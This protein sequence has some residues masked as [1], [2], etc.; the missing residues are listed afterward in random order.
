MKKLILLAAWAIAG[1]LLAADK[2][3]KPVTAEFATA[4]EMKDNWEA[5]TA[6]LKEK[7]E[8]LPEDKKP[9][10]ERDWQAFI[11]EKYQGTEE[12][13]LFDGSR[14]D[15]VTK[16]YAIEL[17]WASET[18]KWAESIGQ[19]LWYATNLDKKPG[20]ILLVPVP[21]TAAASDSPET[22]ELKRGVKSN[23]HKAITVC[24]RAGIKL[25][26]E[27]LYEYTGKTK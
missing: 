9:R 1:V 11:K 3:S 22:A 18:L 17:D 20:V 6:F 13:H 7:Y 24:Q 15:L 8:T 19:S 23:I 27:N 2:P 26:Q 10:T 21:S 25:W 12:W 4:Q 16:D 14:V 5:W